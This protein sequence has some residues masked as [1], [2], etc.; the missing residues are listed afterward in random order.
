MTMT[1]ALAALAILSTSLAGC[2]DFTEP[3]FP[4]AGAPALLQLSLNIDPAGNGS[5]NGVLVPGLTFL[6]F[7]REVPN[8]TLLVNGLR[9]A[10][11]NVRDNGTREY[12][13]SG[14]V[15][16][17]RLDTD[18]PFEVEAVPVEEITSLPPGI[19]WY[20]IEKL[21]S[22]TIAWTRGTDLV[23]N[24]DTALATPSPS[25]QIRQWFLN[26]AGA[27]RSFRLS[28]DGLPPGELRIPTAFI[29]ADANGIIRVTLSFNQSGTYRSA[30]NDY[31][32]SY[33]YAT[34]LQWTIKVDP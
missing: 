4:E 20:T 21:D 14:A 13:V 2:L 19:R 12:H 10:P 23:L 32:G 7:V 16:Q 22:D 34:S 9:V 26:I 15:S 33:T 29:P 28:S 6:G 11:S 24:V 3:D 5:L 18:T 30:G 8:D 25:P 1:R 17:A 27:T 31:I